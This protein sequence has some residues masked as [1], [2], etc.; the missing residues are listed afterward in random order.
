MPRYKCIVSYDGTHFVGFQKQLSARTI[1]GEIENALTQINKKP[2]RIYASG[3]TDSGVHALHQVFHFDSP[4]EIASENWQRAMNSLLPSDVY[5]KSVEPVSSDFHARYN[6]VFKEYRYYLS[7]GEYDPLKYN[8]I[9]QYNRPLDLEKMQEAIQLFVGTHDFRRFSSGNERLTTVRTIMEAAITR[10]GDLLE[11]RFRG[12][13]FLRYQV[14]MMVGTL[15][16]IGE[17]RRSKE[18]I[19]DLLALKPGKAGTTAS[20]NGLYLY[21]V[22][23][24][25]EK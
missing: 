22:E 1:Q 10:Q 25:S 13:G 9:F 15:I 23:Y 16:E 17:L 7:M 11:F 8:Y 14:R 12:N 24:P 18:S 3:R 4:L 5:I 20:P 2:I 21:H 19:Q 6:V